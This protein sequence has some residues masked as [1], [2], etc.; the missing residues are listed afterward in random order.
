MAATTSGAV[1]ARVEA[2]GLGL[3]AYRDGAPSVQG[4]DGPVPS[5]PLPY[6]TVDE[7]V[8]LIPDRDG[9]FDP[10]TLHTVEEMVTVH[11][12]QRWRDG[13]GKTGPEDYGLASALVRVLHGTTLVPCPGQVFGVQVRGRARLLEEKE[14]VV[15]DALTVIVRREV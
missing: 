2:A 12:W 8:A 3:S 6:V 11:L 10:D 13:N 14:N 9:T 5:V 4:P 7:A 1:K 15:H